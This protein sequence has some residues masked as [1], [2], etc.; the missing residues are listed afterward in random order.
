[1]KGQNKVEVHESQTNSQKPQEK[2][3]IIGD[4]F[5]ADTEFESLEKIDKDELEMR[6]FRNLIYSNRGI[7]KTV[8]VVFIFMILGILGCIW[9]FI[10]K[11]PVPD[12]IKRI[13]GMDDTQFPK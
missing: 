4:E 10:Y 2:L 1:M 3:E 12:V 8:D 7:C 5:D 13:F 6:E 11:L 9:V